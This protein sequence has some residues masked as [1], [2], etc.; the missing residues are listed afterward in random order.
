MTPPPLSPRGSTVS[1]SLVPRSSF[2]PRSL[3]IRR[4]RT[5]EQNHR[6]RRNPSGARSVERDAHPLSLAAA[7]ARHLTRCAGAARRTVGGRIFQQG[8][9]SAEHGE[10]AG[11]E[12]LVELD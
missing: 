10:P 9:R 2:A 4:T 1:S 6:L 3:S 8:E 11:V 5:V 7:E 12:A